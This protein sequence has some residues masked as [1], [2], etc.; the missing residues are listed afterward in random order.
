MFNFCSPLLVSPGKPFRPAS[1][2]GIG[3]KGAKL[4]LTNTGGGI[5]GAA[6]MQN[7]GM[8]NYPSGTMFAGEQDFQHTHVHVHVHDI[9]TKSYDPV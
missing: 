4:N 1:V 2:P 9:L 3:V 6:G 8:V 7:I 5:E